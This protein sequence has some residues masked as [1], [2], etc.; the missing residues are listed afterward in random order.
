[1]HFC[2]KVALSDDCEELCDILLLILAADGEG[3][4]GT[5]FV[6]LCELYLLPPLKLVQLLTSLLPLLV[7]QILLL[8]RLLLLL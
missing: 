7:L 8:G 1:M 6:A 3:V 5:L 4:T 2:L